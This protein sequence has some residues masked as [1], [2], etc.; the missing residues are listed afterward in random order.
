MPTSYTD[1]QPNQRLSNVER[2]WMKLLC[3][4]VGFMCIFLQGGE[5]LATDLLAESAAVKWV[6]CEV[7]KV[8]AEALS[9]FGLV[10]CLDFTK[11]SVARLDISMS[12]TPCSLVLGPL[13]IMDYDA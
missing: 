2:V 9:S 11:R 13:E 6:K 4:G 7:S 1:S 12:R 3:E 8:M 5:P 10:C